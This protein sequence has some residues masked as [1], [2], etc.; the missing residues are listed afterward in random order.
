MRNVARFNLGP[1]LILNSPE[2]PESAFVSG[3]RELLCSRPT[4]VGT[5]QRTSANRSS[6]H[7]RGDEIRLFLLVTLVAMLSCQYMT[8]RLLGPFILCTL[9]SISSATSLYVTDFNGNEVLRYD[10]STETSL[11]NPFVSSGSG[12]LKNPGG[13]VSPEWQSLRSEFWHER[14]AGV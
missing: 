10:A 11:G 2:P 1:K 9:A 6:G 4:C 5:N 8:S 12:R 7:S 13:L 14:G 3:F